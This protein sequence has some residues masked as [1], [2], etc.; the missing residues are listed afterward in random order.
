MM[1]SAEAVQADP[2]ASAMPIPRIHAAPSLDGPVIGKLVWSP[3]GTTLAYQRAPAERPDC[4]DLWLCEAQCDSRPRLLAEGAKALAGS[5]LKAEEAG[6][7]ERQRQFGK[8][9]GDFA[10]T[11]CGRFIVT[12]LQAG[13]C[14]ISAATG[15]AEPFVTGTVTDV[16]PAPVGDA[17]AFIQDGALWVARPG[18]SEKRRLSPLAED[19]LYYG[20]AEFVAQEEFARDTG[21][22]WRPDGRAI[23]YTRVDERVVGQARHLAIGA[24]DMRIVTQR[25]P[26]A[27][28][29]NARVDLFVAALDGNAPPVPIDLGGDR[30]VYLL[31]VHWS[32]DGCT[33]LIQRQ[34]RDQRRIDLLAADPRTGASRVI[35]REEAQPWVNPNLDFVP[36]A[37]GSFL[38][39]SERSGTAQ[40]Y[41]HAADGSVI[42]QLTDAP[43]PLAARDRE[44]AIAGID[45]AGGAV[46]VIGGNQDGVTER[47]LYRVPIDGGGAMARVSGE[48]GWWGAVLAPDGKA[49]RRAVPSRWR[50]AVRT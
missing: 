24:A 47:H 25:F 37:D 7:R 3:D 32:R 16:Q 45:E 50:A 12:G 34:T 8:G 33:L 40:L 28:T 41:R 18:I 21:Y 43:F 2:M 15:A 11:A 22:W 30:D 31:R 38:W 29:A 49:S 9:I 44:R 39:V 4:F 6:R 17:V 42:A 35:W 19:A 14:R 13:L 5:V 1:T 20:V 48:P 10:W 36:L 23:A 46:F 27:G 26:K